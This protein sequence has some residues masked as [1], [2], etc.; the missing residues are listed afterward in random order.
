M[1]FRRYGGPE[2]LEPMDLPE[3][4]VGPDW[5]LIRARAASV[6][7]VDWKVRQGGL[8]AL[9]PTHFP[10]ITGWDV[11]GVV[12]R[13]GPA[14]TGVRAGDEVIAYNRQ[15]HLQWGTCA[16]LIAAPERTVGPKPATATWEQAAALPLVGLT[17]HQALTERLAVRAGETVLVHA[18]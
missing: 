3:P 1:A 4:K 2:V 18:A 11:A 9:I 14:V 8:D 17:A 13:V 5:V 7:P 10:V 16:E 12:E 15:D 6:N